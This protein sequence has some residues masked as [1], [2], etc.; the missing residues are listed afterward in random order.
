M[1]KE[2]IEVYDII[3]SVGVQHAYKH[4]KYKYPE[5]FIR[6]NKQEGSRFAEKLYR[7]C[8]G[9]EQYPKCKQCMT[10]ITKFRSFKK[11]YAFFCSNKC[12]AVN[13][14][15]KAKKKKTCQETYGASTASQ[16]EEVDEKRRQTLMDKFGTDNLA[17]IRWRRN[18]DKDKG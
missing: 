14:A 11:G 15:H 5:Y 3:K 12:V 6:I 9:I 2:Q 8:Y 1:N 7:F 18:K 4:I 10:T 13:R 16:S 17:E